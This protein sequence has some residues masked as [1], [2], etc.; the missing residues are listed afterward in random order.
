MAANT[1][2]QQIRE[3]AHRASDG[4]EVVLFWHAGTYELTVSVST[5]EPEPTS[6]LPRSP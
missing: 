1:E 3:L 5:F 4:L 2:T 6:S